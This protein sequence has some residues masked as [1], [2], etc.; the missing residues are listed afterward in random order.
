MA[1]PTYRPDID[2][3]RAV[4]VLPVVL[5]HAGLGFPGGYVGVDVF[6]VISGFLITSILRDDILA[7]RFSLLRFYDRR[8]RRIFPAL[9][10]M[11]GLT[12]LGAAAVLL[13]EHLLAFGRSLRATALF[14]ANLHFW[15]LEGYF[16]EAA[17]LKPLL[18]TWSLAIE[19]QYYLVFPPLLWALMRGRKARAGLAA[20][21]LASFALALWQVRA[22][23]QAAFYLPFGRIWELLAG[24][25]LAL[26]PDLARPLGRAALLRA[27]LG[28]AGLAAILVPVFA[29]DRLTPFPGLAALPPVLG[30][31][32]VL[33][34]GA[35]GPGPVRWLLERAV[36]R[37]I[38]LISYSLY[39]WHW[40]VLVLA[41]YV[42]VLPMTGL[43]RVACLGLS[44]LLA[45][46]SWRCVERPFRGA[47]RP[48]RVVLF[49]GAL[50][51]I[52]LTLVVG[53]ELVRV[54]GWPGR[55]ETRLAALPDP[56]SLMHDRRDCHFVTP[57]RL[58]T[59]AICLRGAP[60][61]QASFVLLG[62][63]HADAL[64]PGIFAAA[65]QAG[66]A[67]YQITTSGFR[68]LPGVHER[69]G[70]DIQPLTEAAIAFLTQHPELHR[71]ILAGYWLHQATGQSYRHPGTVFVDAE[72]DGS[73]LA[74]APV[75]LRH[76]LVA[77]A[78]RLPDR[79]IVLL[80]DPPS[81]KALDLRGWR[82]MAL[83]R[84]DLLAAGAGLPRGEA[85]A[86]RASWEPIL[87][88]VAA[89]MP[90]VTYLPIFND[91]CGPSLCALLG[92]EGPRYR[93]GDHLSAA[94]AQ[95]L[96]P[97]FTSAL[98]PR[99]GQ[100]RSRPDLTLDTTRLR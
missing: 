60:G 38:G 30:T 25:L 26:S 75:A 48:G 28:L 52:V 1:N 62:D 22:A 97:A 84:P 67:G 35:A 59:G 56:K 23:P 55:F 6:F 65:T 24:S 4:A 10:V 87:Q 21:T 20:L 94:T 36:L 64:S 3:L 69:Q 19:E 16:T 86:Q 44:F 70:E 58:A 11:L 100:A 9:F 92:P 40:P 51:A 91:F 78:R 68:P 88:Q 85:A 54:W 61:A 66:E 80:D 18:H 74:Y 45:L 31:V 12:T 89:E 95:A 13:P 33:A 81:G 15:R 50:S 83:W 72:Y 32:A 82:Q 90:N 77:L 34:T 99:P 53:T 63:S 47:A 96:E 43:Q 57:E 71:I 79:Q 14:A 76:G 42:T 39:L 27:L 8:I 73:G 41:G 29:Y 98:F 7:D 5:Y 17:E 93:D 37:G 49:G 2:G 46:L